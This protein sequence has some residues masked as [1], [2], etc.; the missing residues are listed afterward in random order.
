MT[1]AF[2]KLPQKGIPKGEILEIMAQLKKSD[3]NWK[4]GRTWSL[5]YYAGDDHTELLKEAYNMFFSENALNPF[6]FPSLKK[7]ET[8]VVSMAAHILGGGE[9]AAG[10]MTSGGTESILM[11]VKT[12]REWARATKPEVKR[13][14]MILPMTA[15]PAFEKAAHYFDVV[16][17]HVPVGDDFRADIGAARGAINDNSILMVGS[18]PGYPHGV[19]DS[20]SEMAAIA[21]EKGIGFHVDACLGGLLLPFI[22]KLGCQIPDFDFSVPGVTSISADLHKYGF[23]AKGASVIIYRSE[24]LRRYQF[25]VYTDWSGGIYAS[26]G[27]PGTR[28]GG[29]IAAAWACLVAMGEDGYLRSA[30]QIMKT[31]K[32]LTDGIGAI[33]GLYILGKPDASVFAFTS[34]EV[35]IYAVGDAMEA[36][37]WNMDRQQM[38]PSLHIMV[39]LAHGRIVEQFLTDLEASVAYVRENPSA[40]SE[41]MAALYGMT[42]KLPDR[43]IVRDLVLQFLDNLYRI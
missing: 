4:G 38:P 24:D 36:R 20:I 12:Y 22:K 14:E 42:A 21:A 19:I 32:S 29:A 3:S 26:P 40:S 33:P 15:H 17:V 6:A 13:P 31:T 37:G 23:A 16:P 7:F 5:V 39:T 34:D 18:A 10:T 28:P 27:M 43:G 9:N 2:V 41:G 1:D 35:D 8:E 30:E 11:A 25:F